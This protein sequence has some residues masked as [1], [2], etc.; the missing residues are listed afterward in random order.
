MN[1]EHLEEFK[2]KLEEKKK[3]T[4]AQ[5]DEIGHRSGVGKNNFDADFPQYGES[6]ED[7]AVEVADYT[8]NLSL[9][10]ELEKQLAD[11]EKALYRIEK[12]E[13]GVCHF[14]GQEIEAERLKIRPESSACVECKNKIKGR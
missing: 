2:T 5:L 7:S 8:T 1:K 14:C 9:E 6:L 13:Y 12:N 3:Q 11:V 10:R 4:I